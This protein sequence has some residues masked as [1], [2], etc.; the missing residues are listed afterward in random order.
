MKTWLLTILYSQAWWLESCAQQTLAEWMKRQRVSLENTWPFPFIAF[1][2]GRSRKEEI[3][4]DTWKWPNRL[5]LSGEGGRDSEGL[6]GYTGNAIE[7]RSRPRFRHH[8]NALSIS[9]YGPILHSG[10]LS[11]QLLYLLHRN[12]KIIK[13][14]NRFKSTSKRVYSYGESYYL[15]VENMLYS[16]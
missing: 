13:G 3:P 12:V 6:A 7:I 8:R 14:D 10:I 9:S 15:T 16:S 5:R 11:L 2:C 1:W 4:H